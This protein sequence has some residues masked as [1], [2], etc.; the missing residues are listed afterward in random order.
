MANKIGRYEILEEIGRGAFGQVYRAFD[1]DVN[2]RVAVKVLNTIGDPDILA[3]FR[4]E[5]A[6][7]GN[8]NHRNIVTIHDF[9][10]HNGV[11]FIVMELVD[12]QDLQKTMAARRLKLLEKMEIMSQ[13]ADGLHFAH[14]KGVIHRDVKPANIMVLPDGRVKI[15]DFGIARLN[16]ANAARQTRTGYLVGTILYMSPE[17]FQDAIVD[18]LCD[19][20]A[21]GVVYYEM[22]TGKYPFEAKDNASLMYKVTRVDPPRIRTLAPDCP[23]ALEQIVHRALAR[24]REL[25]YQSLDDLQLDA[26]P[27]LADL[28][29]LQAGG[30]MAQARA[31]FEAGQLDEAQAMVR[32]ILDLDP[33]NAEA[34]QLRDQISR[35]VQRRSVRP[36]V[37]NLLKDAERELAERRF[38]EA[39]ESLESAL[40]LDPNDSSIR[41]RLDESRRL[42]ECNARASDLAGQAEREFRLQEFGGAYRLCAEALR[43]DEEHPQA[44]RLM[45]AIQEEIARRDRKRKLEEG[46]EKARGLLRIQAFEEVFS[47]VEALRKEFPGEAQVE[48][49][50][51]TARTQQQERDRRVRL[52]EE[53]QAAR[54]LLRERN[55][56]GAVERLRRVSPEFSTDPQFVELRSFAEEELRRQMTEQEI[57]GFAE[58]AS[59]FAAQN[60]FDEALRAID[61]GLQKYATDSTLIRLLQSTMAAK[62]SFEKEQAIAEALRRGEELRQQGR[63]A[64]ALDL[65]EAAIS[66]SGAEPSLLRLRAQLQSERDQS[67][68]AE[69][70][71]Q[72][73]RQGEELLRQKNFAA[74][75]RLLESAAASYP[76][77]VAEL[78]ARAVVQEQLA[79]AE[80]LESA[81]QWDAALAVLDDALARYPAA[82][83]LAA[84]RERVQQA[85]QFA[86]Q[87]AASRLEIK[88]A[89]ASHDWNLTAML[90]D[91]ARQNL[92]APEVSELQGQLEAGR[93]RAGLDALVTEVQEA[94][95]QADLAHAQELVDKGLAQY[96]RQERLLR[97]QQFLEREAAY[98]ANLNSARKALA[99]RRFDAA[100]D[101]AQKALQ[102]KPA[103]PEAMALVDRIATEREAAERAEQSIDI[104][105]HLARATN[106]ENGGRW[107]AALAVIEQAVA[108]YPQSVELASARAR[109]QKEVQ[110]AQQREARYSEN[111]AAARAALEER[112]FDASADLARKALRVKPADKAALALLE[113]IEVELEA[114][115]RA[116]KVLPD[117]AREIETVA[118]PQP[119]APRKTIQPPVYTRPPVEEPKPGK[120]AV[121]VLWIA[122]GIVG[123]ALPIWLVNKYL[124]G[125]HKDEVPAD[126]TAPLAIRDTWTHP[127]GVRGEPYAAVIESTGGK[128]PIAWSVPR[129]ALPG[130]LTLDRATGRIGGTPNKEGAYA[131][132]AN[133]T[134]H[135]GRKAEH[136]FTITINAPVIVPPGTPLAIS[137]TWEYGTA[138][139]GTRYS[140]VLK[141]TGGSPPVLWSLSSGAL[142]RGLAFDPRG[143]RIEGTPLAE[144][145]FNFRVKAT[146]R[147]RHTAERAISIAVRPSEERPPV[148]PPP[149]ISGSE[150]PAGLRGERYTAV[151]RASGGSGGLAWSLSQGSPPRG[152]TLDASGRMEG[153]PAEE[154]TS[155]FTA[156]VTDREGRS[157]ERA[158]SI[159][160]QGP[161]KPPAPGCVAKPFVLSE[162]GDSQSGTLM[163]SG[164]LPSG[165]DLTLNK[166]SA[167]TGSTRGDGLPAAGIP[168]KITIG[169]GTVKQKDAPSAANCWAAPLVL[170]NDGPAVSSITIS[171]VV[172][173]P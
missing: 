131:F 71:T 42:A 117:T 110:I 147:E 68:R 104:Q 87:A 113:K 84:A 74:A 72:A 34:R 70:V 159:V 2:R 69:E 134:D 173:Q 127:T 125:T 32:R 5:A 3:R 73:L 102:A 43:V 151:L 61:Q 152:V 75:R 156:R 99:E 115:Q 64:D 132:V 88:Q 150:L 133:A 17:Q 158:F 13:V 40:R 52:Q 149:T 51:A 107:D 93:E 86:R 85:F 121:L 167:S 26:G 122:A 124:A 114:A 154:G 144:G 109:I 96:G 50:L 33:A 25:R 62:R 47:A 126:T 8:L 97:L 14:S 6:A 171:W 148:A 35:Q 79:R 163:W 66:R 105:E 166:R 145:Q 37:E 160:V 157:A 76:D 129:G 119:V 12:G 38:G 89:M 106:L 139:R 100:Q 18:S 63:T 136:S 146:D 83:E 120:R 20:W 153:T 23:E 56:A 128:A 45:D 49:L 112:R 29:R 94:V 103:D 27:V 31:I 9:G 22:L 101:A 36:K 162:Y 46:L 30:M 143:G 91:S 41:V 98:R 155:R 7:A 39:T 138:V 123:V 54:Q 116:A 168:V 170:H 67:R 58:Q 130:G 44:R 19:I 161:K 60:R 59:Q 118:P 95:G 111:L 142:P 10:E 165:A 48:Q 21:Y 65:V 141:A 4:N 172:F 28:R 108:R 11:P 1:P 57:A 78:W 77:D 81:Q 137:E 92:P 140:A 16:Q 82:A 80:Q 135:D 24:D 169:S 90:L 53:M 55:F 15:L 164:S